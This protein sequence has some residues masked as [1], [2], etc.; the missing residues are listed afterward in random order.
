[1]KA[2]LGL[3]VLMLVVV[4]CGGGGDSGPSVDVTGTWRVSASDGSA[5]S[6]SLTQDANGVVTGTVDG[7]P[8]TGSVDGNNLSLSASPDPSTVLSIAGTVEGNTMSGNYE[9]RGPAATVTGT[10]TAT[11][12]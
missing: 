9:A 3:V 6:M 10:W 11:K 4:G 8:M 7:I 12:R 5:S 1:M 2:I